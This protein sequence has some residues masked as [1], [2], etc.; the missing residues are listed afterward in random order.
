MQMNVPSKA[1]IRL[2]KSP[3]KGIASAIIKLIKQF[4]MTQ[5]S[6]T[7]QCCQVGDDRCLLPRRIRTKTPLA[8]VVSAEWLRKGGK[9]LRR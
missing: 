9:D 2:N 3:K 1:P 7:V 4:P 6:Q 8:A 5:Q